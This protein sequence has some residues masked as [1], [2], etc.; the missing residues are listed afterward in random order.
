MNKATAYMALAN[1]KCA[2][3]HGTINKTLGVII[4]NESESFWIMGKQRYVRRDWRATDM[5]TGRMV[6]RHKT[7]KD[8]LR[9]LH[10]RF[11]E[12]ER[13]R[14]TEKYAVIVKQ[15]SKS[16]QEYKSRKGVV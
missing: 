1:G 13:I 12:I 11:P 4:H 6:A 9:L 3:I 15:F 10:E 7:K 2:E 8:C 16:I 5:A 14:T